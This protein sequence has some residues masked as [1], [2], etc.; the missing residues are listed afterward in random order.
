M[1]SETIRP[2]K[3]AP[4][5]LPSRAAIVAVVSL[6]VLWEA[7]VRLFNVKAYLVPAPL[8]ILKALT[9]NPAVFWHHTA[10]TLTEAIFGLLIA[11]VTG[12]TVGLAV[13]LRRDVGRAVAPI[14]V[15]IQAVPIIA[16]APLMI[17]WLGSGIASK[18]VMAA[19]L[20]FF[21]MALNTMKG[22]ASLPNGAHDMIV[23][24]RVKPAA[25]FFSIILPYAMPFVFAGARI[26]ASMSVIGAIVAEYAGANAGLGY[27]IMQAT[28]RV[29]T[30][31]LFAAIFCSAIAAWLLYGLTTVC[32]HSLF[33]RFL[34]SA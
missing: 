13:A 16:F 14:L 34:Q 5:L 4:A 12:I 25:A 23:M 27:L 17:F 2:P 10:V 32:E 24:Y 15:G 7:I 11:C 31:D 3:S 6:A 30:T 21:P 28:Y 20:C 22:V 1:N 29:E 8:S 33:R 9:A 26:S 19:M 18:I